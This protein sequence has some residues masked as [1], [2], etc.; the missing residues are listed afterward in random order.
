MLTPIV[1]HELRNRKEEHKR[2]QLIA[3][4]A[5]VLEN[6]GENTDLRPINCG[7]C[8]MAVFYLTMSLTNTQ[9]FGKLSAVKLERNQETSCQPKRIYVTGEWSMNEHIPWLMPTFGRAP[10]ISFARS[11]EHFALRQNGA[12]G[13][14]MTSRRN[15][16]TAKTLRACYS[17]SMRQSSSPTTP[18]EPTATALRRSIHFVPPQLLINSSHVGPRRIALHRS[19]YLK[20]A[21]LRIPGPTVLTATTRPISQLMHPS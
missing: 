19:A 1:Q 8:Y 12:R 9:K 21:A 18:L 15:V 11:R 5:E 4:V 2:I 17:A 6:S 16:T 3:P 10:N 20:Y 14:C 13:R 7:W